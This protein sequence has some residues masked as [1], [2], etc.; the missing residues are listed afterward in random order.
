MARY[1]ECA[2]ILHINAY[3]AVYLM[4]IYY[5]NTY[6]NPRKCYYSMSMEKYTAEEV[7]DLVDDDEIDDESDIE[8]DPAFPLPTLDSDD[9]TEVAL[10]PSSPS[11]SPSPPG[12]GAGDFHVH[13]I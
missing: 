7:A 4:N 13:T 8:E 6:A 3:A 2:Y 5:S 1:C 10:T 11:L 12:Q 9:E